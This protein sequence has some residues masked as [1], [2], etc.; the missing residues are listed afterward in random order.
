M[1]STSSKSNPKLIKC[2]YAQLDISWEYPN[3]AG[4][5]CN[6]MSPDDSKNFLSLLKKLRAHPVGSE[7]ILTAAVAIT[8]FAGSDGSPMN[9]VSEFATV[10]NFIG[11]SI[12]SP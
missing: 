11:Q 8:P 1:A 7:L 5:G 10:L 9:D 6:V 12:A 4:I 3:E 2:A